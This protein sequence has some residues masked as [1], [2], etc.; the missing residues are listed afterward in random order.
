ME[1]KYQA[2]KFGK[3][4]TGKAYGGTPYPASPKQVAFIAK[5]RQERGMEPLNESL[6]SKDASAMIDT[7]LTMPKVTAEPYELLT[8][9]VYET[10]EGVYVVKQTKDKER[11]YAKRLIEIGGSRVTEAGN[12]VQI[13]FVYEPGAINRIKL[14]DKMD[15]EKG[16]ALAVRYGRCLNCGRFLKAAVSVEQG[17]G[18]VC[19]K[20][21]KNWNAAVAATVAPPV[22]PIFKGFTTFAEFAES[23]EWFDGEK[24]IEADYR[25]MWDRSHKDAA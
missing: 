11:L 2:P 10:A 22:P 13:D 25:A 24:E 18:P 3:P 19:I 23:M 9:G 7:L 14:T 8:P 12:H 20:S 4:P 17:I 6:S 16:K 15:V 5:L 21:Y 1:F